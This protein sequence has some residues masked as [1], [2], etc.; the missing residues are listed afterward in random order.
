MAKKKKS[1]SDRIKCKKHH[2]SNED[3]E[4]KCLYVSEQQAAKKAI[5]DRERRNLK[6]LQD[7]AEAIYG[8]HIKGSDLV[9]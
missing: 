5:Q 3:L 2:S 8:G 6:A 1:D 4:C 9:Y 7:Q